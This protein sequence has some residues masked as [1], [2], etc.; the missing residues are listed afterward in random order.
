MIGS[1]FFIHLATLLSIYP[2]QE[3]SGEVMSIYGVQTHSNSFLY[4]R[5][6]TPTFSTGT[7]A[8]ENSWLVIGLM[9][10][11]PTPAGSSLELANLGLLFFFARVL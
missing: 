7:G 4:H 1:T 10:K 5:Q 8:S 9:E 2:S 6:R 11:H 3:M